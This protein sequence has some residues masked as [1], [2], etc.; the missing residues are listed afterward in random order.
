MTR[1][2]KI[3]LRD[4]DSFDEDDKITDSHTFSLAARDHAYTLLDRRSKKRYGRTLSASYVLEKGDKDWE[5]ICYRSNASRIPRDSLGYPDLVM[6]FVNPKGGRQSSVQHAYCYYAYYDDDF[7]WFQ[8]HQI[9]KCRVT[10]YVSQ[11]VKTYY[12]SVKT[13]SH[14]EIKATVESL[15]SKHWSVE[16]ALEDIQAGVTHTLNQNLDETICDGFQFDYNLD[17]IEDW[18]LLR[19]VVEVKLLTNKPRVPKK[20]GK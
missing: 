17:G 1:P 15:E 7:M 13:I 6:H 16:T 12:V 4:L 14:I 8:E 3:F 19:E 11:Y 5:D 20:E 2:I 10:E 9:G 18:T